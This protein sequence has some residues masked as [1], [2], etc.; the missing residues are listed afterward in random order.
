MVGNAAESTSRPAYS[1]GENR[2]D[3]VTRLRYRQ[4]IARLEQTDPYDVRSWES[5]VNELKT[6][7]SADAMSREEF[8][9]LTYAIAVA[10][11]KARR[12]ARLPVG[13]N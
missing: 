5:Y 2:G 10:V 8:Q 11:V 12:E 1:N 3:A 6:A 4:W 7:G 9:D 13:S